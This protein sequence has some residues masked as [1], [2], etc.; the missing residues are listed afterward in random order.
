M[1]S[2][3]I[4]VGAGLAGLMAGRRLLRAGRSVRVIEARERAG[5]RTFTRPFAGGVVD[6]GGTW[7]GPTQKRV[8]ALAAELGVALEAQRCEGKSLME[9]GSR[10]RAYRGTIPALNFVSLIELQRAISKIDRMAREVP[11]GAPQTAPKAR[12]WDALTVGAFLDAEIHTGGARDTMA[13]AVR[14]IFSSEPREV[15]LLYFL[16][17]VRCAGGIMPLCE[18]AGGAQES[19]LVGG[20]QQLSDRL[21]VEIAENPDGSVLFGQPVVAI[22]QDERGVRVRTADESFEAAHLV[23]AVPPH[24]AARIAF[25]PG[26][27]SVRD[28]LCQ[29]LPIGASIK[30]I[31]AYGRPFWREA[32][33][34]GEVVTGSGPVSLAFDVGGRDD[35]GPGLLMS[36]LLGDAARRMSDRGPVE[37]AAAVTR[38]LAGFFGPEAQSPL[39]V[40]EHDWMADPWA[41]GCSVGIGTAGTLTTCGTALREPMGRIHLAGTETA[42]EWAGFMDGALQ[43]GERAAAEI[44]ARPLS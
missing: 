4:V 41:R 12:V 40:I 42:T 14:A 37:R 1:R 39:E 43:S 24:L 16:W 29:R 5:G 30:V 17:Y 19:R 27:P 11:A 32:G 22:A 8:L 20:A 13:G 15:S 10:M 44:V 35:E 18:V 34:S 9:V 26:L 2:D 6:V 33:W 28:Q 7:V 38:A 31:T 36:F 3:T 25:E 23:L 21:A